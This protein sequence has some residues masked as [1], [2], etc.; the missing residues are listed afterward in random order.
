MAAPQIDLAH[1]ILRSDVN[2][3]MTEEHT[4]IAATIKKSDKRMMQVGAATGITALGIFAYG[5]CRK[6]SGEKSDAS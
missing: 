4:V 1:L 3:L 5:M 2:R 6:A